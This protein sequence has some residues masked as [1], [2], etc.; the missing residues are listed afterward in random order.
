VAVLPSSGCC[1]S[2]SPWFAI[3]DL[4]RLLN[5]GADRVRL[6]TLGLA[7]LVRDRGAEYRENASLVD[8]TMASATSN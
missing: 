2:C 3:I 6:E 1:P 4:S 8:R 5:F 7:V